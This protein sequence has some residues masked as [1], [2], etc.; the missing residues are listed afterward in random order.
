MHYFRIKFYQAKGFPK[1]NYIDSTI[2]NATHYQVLMNNHVEGQFT[3]LKNAIGL[4][5]GLEGQD[6][7]LDNLIENIPKIKNN[8]SIFI[9]TGIIY[10]RKFGVSIEQ[11]IRQEIPLS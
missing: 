10:N 7:E 8:D 2:E 11:K 6:K 4:I 5:I 1:R 9:T 3:K